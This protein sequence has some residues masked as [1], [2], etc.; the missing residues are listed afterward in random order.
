MEPIDIKGRPIKSYIFKQ[1]QNIGITLEN[2]EWRESKNK[3]NLFYK[4]FNKVTVFADM[5]GTEVIPIWEEPYPY[6]YAI[7]GFEDWERR[8]AIRLALRDFENGEIEHRSSFYDTSEPDGLF[9]GPEDEQADGFCK[10]CEAEI[11]AEDMRTALFCSDHCDKAYAQLKE[12]RRENQENVTKCVLCGKPLG[13]FNSDTILHHIQYEPSEKIVHV[14]R[15]CHRK[16]HLNH[17]K[18]PDLAPSRP[19]DWRHIAPARYESNV[20]FKDEQIGDKFNLHCSRV[21]E[22]FVRSRGESVKCE[23]GEIG[24]E[25]ARYYFVKAIIDRGVSEKISVRVE[26][27]EVYLDKIR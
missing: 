2:F 26:G 10:M 17:D 13:A 8:K 25:L 1:L 21:L 6:I 16:I 18:Y 19:P 14:C 4:T 15:S 24:F 5:R 20:E 27:A 12:M 23:V 9:F 11:I 7:S 3:P 22:S